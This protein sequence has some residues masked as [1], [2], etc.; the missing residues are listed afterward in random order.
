MEPEIPV[1]VE[2]LYRY[3]VTRP[4]PHFWPDY[5]KKEPVQGHGLWSFYQG[6][7]LGLRL[8]VACLDLR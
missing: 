4:N 3:F 8:A 2:L 7:Q 6:I 5:L 1:I